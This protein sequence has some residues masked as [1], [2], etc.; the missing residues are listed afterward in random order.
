V[1]HRRSASMTC[2]SCAIW[3][4]QLA[5]ADLPKG[6]RAGL[7]GRFMAEMPSIEATRGA[8]PAGHGD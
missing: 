8:G 3:V 4:D 5:A 7:T 2:W 1:R 6:L